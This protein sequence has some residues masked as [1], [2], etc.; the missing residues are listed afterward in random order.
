MQYTFLLEFTKENFNFW[1]MQ[2]EV[3]A[4]NGPPEVCRPLLYSFA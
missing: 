4:K 1:Y 3:H 2:G